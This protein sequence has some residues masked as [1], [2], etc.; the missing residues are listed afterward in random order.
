MHEHMRRLVT[1]FASYNFN[2]NTVSTLNVV[3]HV[4]HIILFGMQREQ[5]GMDPTIVELFTRTQKL[6][7]KEDSP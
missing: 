1:N 5:L 7:S 6:H 4:F 3:W 2:F